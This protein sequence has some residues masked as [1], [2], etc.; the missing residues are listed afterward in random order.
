MNNTTTRSIV[1]EAVY[2]E[3]RHELI[4]RVEKDI[5]SQV[6]GDIRING[7]N[8]LNSIISREINWELSPWR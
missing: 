1:N 6:A 4:R 3:V 8:P 5:L 2:H 7:W